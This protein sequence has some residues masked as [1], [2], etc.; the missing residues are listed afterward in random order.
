MATQIKSSI[1][2]PGSSAKI[3]SQRRK[4]MP[5]GNSRVKINLSHRLYLQHSP[6][7][8]EGELTWPIFELLH[9][10]SLAFPRAGGLYAQ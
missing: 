4:A 1:S 3:P 2:S 8:M 10:H 6:P 7:L 9:L 5:K